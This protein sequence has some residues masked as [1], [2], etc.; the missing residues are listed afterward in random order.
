MKTSIKRVDKT[1]ASPAEKDSIL[2][3]TSRRDVI[4][5]PKERRLVPLNVVVE[6]PKGYVF[7]VTPADILETKGL[8]VSSKIVNSTDEQGEELKISV[9][10]LNSERAIV[11]RGDIVA[12]GFLIKTEKVGLPR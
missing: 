4:I 10:N 1:L 8:S 7:V 5:N 6:P 2:Y 12:R 3:L 11:L 9:Y